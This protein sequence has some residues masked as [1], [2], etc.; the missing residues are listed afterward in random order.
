MPPWLTHGFQLLGLHEIPGKVH[1]Y[2][3][4]AM[5]ADCGHPEVKDDETAWCAAFVGSCLAHAGI[6]GTKKLNALSYKDWGR[7]CDP[8]VG[9]IGVK[10]RAGGASWQGHVGFIVAANHREITMLGGNQSDSVSIA[11]FPIKDFVAVRWP[12]PC[13]AFPVSSAAEPPF[14]FKASAA[15]ARES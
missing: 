13:D 10:R 1:D 12:W 3:V 2:R 15:A 5:F 8:K 14:T 4:V 7:T 6:E 9:A 11:R